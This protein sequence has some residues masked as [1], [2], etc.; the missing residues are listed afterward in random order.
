MDGRTDAGVVSPNPHTKAL[1]SRNKA[2]PLPCLPAFG[3]HDSHMEQLSREANIWGAEA[4]LHKPPPTP[5]LIPTLRK[6]TQRRSS[7]ICPHALPSTVL[8]S[9]GRGRPRPNRQGQGSGQE[10]YQEM[11]TSPRPSYASAL[12]LKSC[13]SQAET[14][15]PWQGAGPPAFPGKE[16]WTSNQKTHLGS[17]DHHSSSMWPGT[18]H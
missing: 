1:Q 16:H 18:S 2:C 15:K 12:G 9:L 3:R 5:D 6:C 14:T 10:E 8:L 4:L 17:R 13:G 11:G 7:H